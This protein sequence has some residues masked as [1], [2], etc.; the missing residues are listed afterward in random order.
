MKW[1][2]LILLVSCGKHESPPPVDLGDHDGDQI[3]NHLETSDKEKY[4]ANFEPLGVIKGSIIINNSY[5]IEVKFSNNGDDKKRAIKLMTNKSNDLSRKEYFSEWNNLILK[6][7]SDFHQLNQ[8]SYVLELNFDYTELRPDELYLIEG[9]EHTRLASWNQNMKIT[10][11]HD[12]VHRLL[13]GKATLSLKRN[14]PQII[15]NYVSSD[16]SIKDKTYRVHFFD[17]NKSS[18][19]YVSRKL[20]FKAFKDLYDIRETEQYSEESIFFNYSETAPPLWYEKNLKNGDQI[21]VYASPQQLKET[22][23]KRFQYNKNVIQRKNGFPASPLTLISSKGSV[24]LR[25]KGTK[26]ER[27]FEESVVRKNY[28][29]GNPL[30]G[31]TIVKCNHLVR[32]I[33]SEV[34]LPISYQ[35][36]VGEMIINR[37]EIS[38]VEEQ[39]LTEGVV[40]EMKIRSFENSLNL[41]LRA[42]PFSTYVITGEYGPLCRKYVL[43]PAQNTSTE[44]YLT[45]EI[46]S[47][48]EKNEE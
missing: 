36:L 17:G 44:G 16:Q 30:H 25:I 22:L 32:Q 45:L 14:L 40:W 29:E 28:V 26:S 23:L 27:S 10:L 6:R 13:N 5:P 35:E 18:I 2:I 12:K 37:G 7:S 33:S 34:N 43:T 20:T 48:I 47:Y 11:S 9:D 39:T 3:L 42:L 15:Q 21:L 8:M 19:F 1:I 24:Y 31:G 38:R 46:E 41:N 4:I